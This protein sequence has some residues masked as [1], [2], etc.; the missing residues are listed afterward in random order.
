MA[1]PARFELHPC[2]F[3]EAKAFVARFHRHHQPPQGHKFSLKAVLNGCVVGVAIVG[4][5]VGRHQD[6]GWTLEITRLCTDG[7]RN[8]CSFLIGR[9]KRAGRALGYKRLISYTLMTEPGASWRASGME[10]VGTVPPGK[11]AHNEAPPIMPLFLGSAS[12]QN[13]HPL[14]E[15]RRWEI[16]L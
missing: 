12:R 15:K 1:E 3:S 2:S 7:T 16:K 11:W 10:Q 6:D 13:I 4:R 5:P 14:G 9:V 8:A